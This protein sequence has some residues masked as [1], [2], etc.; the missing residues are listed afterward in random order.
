M[1]RMTMWL[2][3][4]ACGGAKP[5]PQPAWS[6]TCDEQCAS[7][8]E[9]FAGC[10]MACRDR[11]QSFDRNAGLGVAGDAG[12]TTFDIT[13]GDGGVFLFTPRD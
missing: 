3:L 13:V 5:Q 11:E 9:W 6:M 2:V 1:L 10:M 12:I 8:S 7:Q 4:V